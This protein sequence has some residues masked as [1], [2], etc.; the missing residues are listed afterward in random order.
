GGRSHWVAKGPAQLRAEWAHR[1]AVASRI[2][3]RDSG[4]G[5]VHARARRTQHADHRAS[6]V[7]AAG[8]RAGAVFAMLF[9]REP[10]QTIREDLRQLKQVLEAG[11][12][13]RATPS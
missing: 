2:A 7:R 6:P 1:V 12:I 13:A 4:I 8:G 11:E 5:P 9:G 3:R 10:S